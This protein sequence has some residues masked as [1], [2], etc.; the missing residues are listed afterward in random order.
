MPKPRGP[1]A[2][3]DGRRRAILDA[4]LDVFTRTGFAA[5]TMEDVRAR[6][7]A[8]T[9]SVYHHFRSKEQLAG[10]LYVEALR[11]YQAGFVTVLRGGH[12][13]RTVRALVAYHLRWVERRPAWARWLLDMGRQAELVATIDAEVR[14]LN[15]TFAATVLAWMTPH[16]ERATLRA[17]PPEL[18]FAIL[19]GPAQVFTRMWLAGTARV[20]MAQAVRTLGDAAWSSLAG[21]AA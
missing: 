10:A 16:V 19:V 8:S 18:C 12:P 21:D 17:L 2:A 15:E 7:G 13:K 4:A 20:S 3:A 9:G 14:A 1:R 6:A 11:D 5:A